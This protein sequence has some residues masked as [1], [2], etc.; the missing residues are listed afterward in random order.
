MPDPDHPI[1]LARLKH[2]AID[3]L[4]SVIEDLPR[5][6]GNLAQLVQNFTVE[7]MLVLINKIHRDREFQLSAYVSVYT[8]YFDEIED[9]IHKL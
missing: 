4:D 8:V 3:R 1:G 9:L 5:Y 7:E 6:K 2:E